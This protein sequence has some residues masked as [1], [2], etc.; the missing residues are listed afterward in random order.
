M[1]YPGGKRPRLV[2]IIQ[3]MRS[4]TAKTT[5][6]GGGKFGVP[7]G[8]TL[9]FMERTVLT[10]L[11]EIAVKLPRVRDLRRSIFPMCDRSICL[12]QNY[13]AEN[14]CKYGRG[15]GKS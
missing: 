12:V 15:N 10:G 11:G 9:G 13:S 14:K 8:P 6:G 3:I 5:P 7:V 4:E 1:V 2:Y